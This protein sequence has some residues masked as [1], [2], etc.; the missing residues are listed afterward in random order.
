MHLQGRYSFQAS[1]RRGD[2]HEHLLRQLRPQGVFL[3]DQHA[4]VSWF[5]SYLCPSGCFQVLPQPFFVSGP[6]CKKAQTTHASL[7]RG[8][9]PRRIVCSS[10]TKSDVIAPKS[11]KISH[12]VNNYSILDNCSSALRRR[13]P[14]IL[15]I[16]K[17]AVARKTT[18]FVASKPRRLIRPQRSSELTHFCS[19]NLTHLV[20]A[21][22]P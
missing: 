4:N 21:N 22:A 16:F 1:T 11:V 9:H 10:T 20:G 14:S 12:F 17:A 18:S 8:K 7:G 3:A 19:P 2:C 6:R 5:L 13:H 15:L